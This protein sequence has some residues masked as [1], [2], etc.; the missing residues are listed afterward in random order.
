MV[1][2]DANI[3]LRI[4]LRD[5]LEMMEAAINF[6]EE[7]DAFAHNEVI[8]E[9]VYVLRKHYKGEKIELCGEIMSIIEKQIVGVENKE[10][11]LLALQTF[12]TC[13]LD[14]VDC[15]LYAYNQVDC[16]QVFT[17]DK[18]LNKLIKG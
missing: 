10:A 12:A 4:L 17:F 13:N 8:A 9:V 7:N 16:T 6:V 2:I 1:L 14:F 5:N 15:L 3:L 11:M 18:A